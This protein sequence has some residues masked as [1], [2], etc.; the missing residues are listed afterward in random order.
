MI[1]ARP[2]RTIGTAIAAI[3]L[4]ATAA[5]GSSTD[6]AS[7][8]T[9]G[10]TAAATSTAASSAADTG[11]AAPTS[12][13]TGSVEPTSEPTV[14]EP[15]TLHVW[16]QGDTLKD[17]D[18]QALNGEFEAA[19]PGVTVDLQ[20]QTWTDYT[21]KVTT[22]LADTSGSG[23]D[24]LELGNTQVA[25]FAGAGALMELDAAD[26]DNSDTW[27]EGL[28]ESA[29]YDGK[30]IAV[31]YYAGVRVGIYRTDLA[32]TAGVKPPFNSIDDLQAAAVKLMEGKDDSYSG[33][34]FPSQYWY[35]GVSFVW[36][37]GGEIATQAADGT[38]TG[39]LDSDAAKAGLTRLKAFVD[40]TSRGG[41]GQNEADDA[42]VMAQDQAAM[43]IDASWKPAVVSDPTSGN[44][45]LK[46][47]VGIFVVPGTKP[48]TV[49]PQFLGGSDIAISAK[50]PN[51]DLAKEYTKMLTGQKYQ[52]VLAGKGYIA[53]STSFEPKAGDANAEVVVQ[54]ASTGR[55]V[56]NSK[57]WTKVED[58]QILQNMFDEILTGSSS[59]DDATAKASQEI[60]EIL[61]S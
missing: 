19:H 8:S 60:T 39:A 18:I 43:F 14:S 34:Y 55:F 7:T 44:P 23:P 49:M 17:I 28:K 4:L 11:S 3:A 51:A 22:G 52:A 42:L 9:A 10:T 20:E 59:I 25:Q 35:E 53:N 26:F 24:V 54:A 31:P 2:A 40:A 30:L 5:C 58:G 38:W 50:S 29:T 47:K 27:L 33:L 15:A 37:A 13:A 16:M 56:P 36:D 41:E 12:D 6:S 46:D 57:N 1:S 45:D 61:N 48:G 32:E 21:T